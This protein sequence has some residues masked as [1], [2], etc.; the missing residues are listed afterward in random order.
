[1]LWSYKARVSKQAVRAVYRARTNGHGLMKHRRT[2]LWLVRWSLFEPLSLLIAVSPILFLFD[3][4]VF[5]LSCSL[6]LAICSTRLTGRLCDA[7]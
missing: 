2:S 6:A 7:W 1:M 5:D 4:Y 3:V